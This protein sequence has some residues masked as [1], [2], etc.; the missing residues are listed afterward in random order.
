MNIREIIE[1]RDKLKNELAVVEKFLEI[2]KRQEL[3]N[4]ES[5]GSGIVLPSSSSEQTVL[6]N[7]IEQTK[8]GYGSIGKTVWEAIKICPT[9]FTV[10]DIAEGLKELKH[11]LNQNQIAVALNR[12]CSQK[13]IGVISHKVGRKA[14]IYRRI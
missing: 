13:K 12:F 5:T 9:E 1:I 3:Q 6:P 7:V 8:G 10:T 2:A 4:S 11:S 14:A